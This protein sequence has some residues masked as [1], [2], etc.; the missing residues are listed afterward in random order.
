MSTEEFDENSLE[1][2]LGL[3]HFDIK[4]HNDR[5]DFNTKIV[6]RRMENDSKTE[7]YFSNEKYQGRDDFSGGCN[8]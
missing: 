4:I 7:K 2:G 6:R 5:A 1:F 8:G 3:I